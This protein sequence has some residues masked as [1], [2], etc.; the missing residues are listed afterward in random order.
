MAESYVV[1][2]CFQC[3]F[4]SCPFEEYHSCDAPGGNDKFQAPDSGMPDD[5][6]LQ[7]DAVVVSINL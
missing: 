6:P 7:F 2:H 5:C 3:P 1:E 4:I